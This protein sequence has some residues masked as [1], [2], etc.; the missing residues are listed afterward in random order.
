VELD[1]EEVKLLHESLWGSKPCLRLADPAESQEAILLDTLLGAIKT[2]EV[3]KRVGM[4][5]RSTAPGLDGI[6]LTALVTGSSQ[7]VLCAV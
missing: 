3:R 5:K 6:K 7:R 1:R 4:T 2:D